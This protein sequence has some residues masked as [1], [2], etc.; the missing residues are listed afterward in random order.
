MCPSVGGSLFDQA[1]AEPRLQAAGQGDD[2]VGVAR[3]QLGIDVG[4]AAVEAL[5]VAGRGEL[6]EVA[7]AGVVGGQ[8]RQV[9]A[10]D[11]ALGAAVVDEIGLEAEY[12]LDPVL[13]AGLEMLDGS[14]HHAV[15]G[16]T[17]RRHLELRRPRRHRVDLARPVEQRVLAVDVQMCDV[18]AHR[19][20]MASEP[21]V[22]GRRLPK[23][24]RSCSMIWL[25]RHGDAEDVADDDAVAA[26]DRKG[27]TS[28]ACRGCGAEEAGFGDRSV[29]DEPK[30][31]SRGHG[32]TGMRTR[33][34]SK[35]ELSEGL[36]RRRLRPGRAR[37]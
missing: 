3:Q 5:E 24:R 14:V 6:D 29:S 31:E 12:R 37:R 27:R 19:S 30:A 7:K 20:I 1:P 36:A 35:P 33:S 22:T 28:G 15:V 10:L 9:V 2:T 16:E 25:L 13:A 17:Q 34:A 23:L 18:P 21:D 4:L 26:T 11:A 8:Q 32:Q